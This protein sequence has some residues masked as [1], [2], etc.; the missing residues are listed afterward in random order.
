M[1]G[2]GQCT[3]LGRSPERSSSIPLWAPFE[4]HGFL[5]TPPPNQIGT[6]VP[7]EETHSFPINNAAV[8]GFREYSN[9]AAFVAMELERTDENSPTMGRTD[10]F[11]TFGRRLLVVR[12]GVNQISL[13]LCAQPSR[14][15]SPEKEQ[16]RSNTDFIATNALQTGHHASI[17]TQAAFSALRKIA[18]ITAM[19]SIASD[20]G[21]G[22]SNGSFYHLPGPNDVT[23]LL[24]ES[25]TPN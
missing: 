19:F 21:V 14:R 13:Q 2:D 17:S 5:S 8:E 1:T 3:A 20:K 7:N 24:L 9:S 4:L 25:N 15:A 10:R 12:S 11:I 22:Q 23:I 6:I 18:S 16:E